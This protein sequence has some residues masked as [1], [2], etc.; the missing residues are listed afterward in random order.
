MATVDKKFPS[1]FSYI[2]WIKL[3]CVS[4]G[5]VCVVQKFRGYSIWD[6]LNNGTK[7][8]CEWPHKNSTQTCSPPPRWSL[9]EMQQMCMCNILWQMTSSLY[10]SL[11]HSFQQYTM[12]SLTAHYLKCFRFS[13]YVLQQQCHS[14]QQRSSTCPYRQ[15]PPTPHTMPNTSNPPWKSL[16]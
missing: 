1:K 2:I 8:D 15:Q 12:H 6:S 11:K 5:H 16:P 7:S 3:L 4:V 9:P 13:V 14:H 10:P